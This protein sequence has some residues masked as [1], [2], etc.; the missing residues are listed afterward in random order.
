[1]AAFPF[2]ELLRNGRS[3]TRQGKESA[4]VGEG[5]TDWGAYAAHLGGGTEGSARQFVHYTVLEFR[6]CDVDHT[7][8]SRQYA[9]RAEPGR[10]LLG[11]AE[12]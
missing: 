11:R 1:M 10:A 3:H 4:P 8:S 5:A 6:R 7:K 9:G 12:P 2:S